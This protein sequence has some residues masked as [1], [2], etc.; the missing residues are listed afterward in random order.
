MAKEKRRFSVAM[1]LD[2]KGGATKLT[3]EEVDN[4]QPGDGLLWIDLNLS[5]KTAREWLRNSGKVETGV[6]D[7][8]LAVETTGKAVA[9]WLARRDP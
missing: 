2:G 1:R 7:I 8:L 9:D 4:W 3:D 5:N 6:A